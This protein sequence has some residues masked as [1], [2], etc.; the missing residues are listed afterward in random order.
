MPY[1]DIAYDGYLH[2]S[3]NLYYSLLP[4][5]RGWRKGLHTFFIWS[6]LKP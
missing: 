5:E 3:G 6:A 1:Y 4:L 2:C